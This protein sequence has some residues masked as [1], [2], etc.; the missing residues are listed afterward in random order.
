MSKPQKPIIVVARL[1]FTPLE[2]KAI[3]RS[4][5]KRGYATRK[6]LR[7][8]VAQW[9]YAASRGVYDEYEHGEI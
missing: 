9:V 8:F 4:I 6:D 7:H 2:R 5:G 3:A 1:S